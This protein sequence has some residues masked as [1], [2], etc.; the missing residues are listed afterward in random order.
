MTWTNDAPKT[1]GLYRFR[2]N[3][4]DSIR[5]IV[6][7]Y[8]HGASGCLVYEE[9]PGWINA[10]QCKKIEHPDCQWS[11]TPIPEPEEPQ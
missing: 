6:D 1:P 4:A 11:S 8:K 5:W 10:V 7:V 3:P 9:P 2:R